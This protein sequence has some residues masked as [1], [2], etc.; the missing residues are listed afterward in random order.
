LVMLHDTIGINAVG[1]GLGHDITATVD[2]N[3]NEIIVL[4][5]LYE[6]DI[7]DEH[8]GTIHYSLK[9]LAAGRHTIVVK[10]WNIFNYSNTATIVFY[11]HGTDT[12]T[13]Q[14]NASPNPATSHTLLRM[15]HNCKGTIVSAELNIYNIQG[16]PVASFTPPVNPDSYVV[17]PVDWNLCSYSGRRVA[18]G[19]YMARFQVTTSDG[20]KIIQNGKIVVH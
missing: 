9:D 2:N 11:V 14:F 4:N 12:T 20:E 18:P 7:N 10:A 15:E 17:G 19:I 8:S 1:S 3:P 5:D 16:Q 6:T 13:T